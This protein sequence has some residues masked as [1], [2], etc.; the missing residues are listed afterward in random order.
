MASTG[1]WLDP[2]VPKRDWHCLNIEDLGP[3]ESET[4]EMCEVMDIRYVHEMEHDE[5][6]EILR[7]GCIC[8]GHMELSVENAKSREASF[9]RLRRQ[10]EKFSAIPGWELTGDGGV[11]MTNA[12]GFTIFLYPCMD[13]EGGWT[14]YVNHRSRHFASSSRRFSAPAAAAIGALT[15]IEDQAQSMGDLLI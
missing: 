12:R 11:V 8:A 7:C 13:N 9:R 1:K 3:G 10:L 15:A 2:R 4:C 14:F 6:P 5:Y